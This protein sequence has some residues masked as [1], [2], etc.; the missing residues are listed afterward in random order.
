M[1]RSS[2]TT[3]TAFTVEVEFFSGDLLYG[4]ETYQVSAASWYQAE[5]EA[6]ARSC[7]SPYDDDRVPGRRRR[8]NAKA[9]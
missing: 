4:T 3:L 5:Q 7:D 6:L 1:Q 9:V 8:A 2:Q